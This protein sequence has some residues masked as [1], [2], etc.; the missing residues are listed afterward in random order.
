VLLE[1][2]FSKQFEL[3][4]DVLFEFLSSKQFDCSSVDPLF[5]YLS[6]NQ[7]QKKRPKPTMAGASQTP[8]RAAYITS[9][10]DV[11]LG[12]REGGGDADISFVEIDTSTA[13]SAL[14]HVL[15]RAGSLKKL[16]DFGSLPTYLLCVEPHQILA[17]GPNS[18]KIRDVLI[19]FLSMHERAFSM[20]H[21]SNQELEPLLLSEMM[22]R[23]PATYGT[24]SKATCQR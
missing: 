5:A 18:D 6:S 4:V 9:P 2:L 8:L 20:L 23:C 12:K 22:S 1:I 10:P 3:S 15:C 14:D 13:V 17:A 7:L 11:T 24:D 16:S 21:E 19:S